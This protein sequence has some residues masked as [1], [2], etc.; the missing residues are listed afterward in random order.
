MAG[1]SVQAQAISPVQS[2]LAAQAPGSSRATSQDTEL[3]MADEPVVYT[4]AKTL[5]RI[6]DSPAAV[7][8][9]TEAQIQS[10]GATNI[11]DLLRSVPG[12]DVMEPNKSQAN[13]SIR[14]FNAIFSNTLLVMVDGRAINQP[15]LG[16]VFWNTEPLLLTQIKR[17][18]IVR[19]PGSVL[20]GANAFNGVI[21][22]ITK[23]PAEMLETKTPISLVGAYGEHE[24]A[25]TEGTYS[26]G[27]TN[28]WALTLGAGYHATEGFGGPQ[29]DQIHDRSEVPI[30]T[31]DLQKQ[32]RHGSLLFSARNSDAKTD[33]SADIVVPNADFHTSSVSLSY[34]TDH[35]ANPI[36]AHAYG[37]FFRL[38]GNNFYASD[39]ALSLD[40]QQQRQLSAKHTLIYGGNYRADQ[41]T[42]TLTGPDRQHEQL[43]GLYLQ[44]QYQIGAA[45]SLFAGLRWD[46]HSVYGSQVSPRLSLVHHLSP[47]QSV[48][49]SYGTAFRA[50]TLIETYL[51]LTQPLVPGLDIKLAGNTSLTPEKIASTEAGY[52]VDM[53]GG[54]V[55]LSVFYNRISDIIATAPVQFAPSPPF[56]A[57]IPTEVQYQ[58][59]G[60]ARAFGLELEGS[61]QIKDGWHGLANYAYQDVRNDNGQ[62][63]DL[64]P[65]HKVNLVVESDSRRRWTAYSAVHFVS[66]SVYATA[67]LRAYTTVDARL[68]YRLGGENQPWTVS[69]AATNLLDDHH[70]E[71]AD[72][73]ATGANTAVTE[74]MRR[75]VWFI[76]S[77]KL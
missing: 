28:D 14:G 29:T 5:Q 76:I 70:R 75:T 52:R 19:G 13:V 27:R 17:I 66:D 38:S 31:A 47:D 40:V 59:Q 57:G 65:K 11:P 26:T 46:Q 58:N 12:V 49:L 63:T 50:P 18:E 53:R 68:G 64:S 6:S 62:P 77:G 3:L 22:I 55:G 1:A 23:T 7:T 48:R 4:A 74:S 32:L 44:D 33:L 37:N 30:L 25:F 56:P 21:N 69:V 10:S 36:T 34:A 42:F 43:W 71:Y 45:T 61:F 39:S 16:N 67:S 41:S 72:V 54:Y 51:D 8:V 9:I 15:I 20:Y 60:T 73:V 2:G 24:S 35:E